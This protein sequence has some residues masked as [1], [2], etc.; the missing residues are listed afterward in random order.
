MPLDVTTLKNSIQ[1]AFTT[2][3]DALGATTLRDS[4]KTALDVAAATTDPNQ[5]SATRTTLAQS[6][7]D[8][9]KTF[10]KN[11]SP[12][13]A[14][15]QAVADAI[16]VFVSPLEG[17]GATYY[18]GSPANVGTAAPGI[19]TQV[20][21]GDHV[22]G[23]G[24]LAGGAFHAAASG[25]SAGF[26]STTDKDKLDSVTVANIP[27]VD[28]KAALAGTSGAPGDGNRYVT[29]ADSRNT[30]SRTP[31]AH[32]ASHVTGG[33][34]VIA[35]AVAGGAAGLLSGSDKSKLDGIEALADVTDLANVSAALGVTN[36]VA[37]ASTA[38]A[39]DAGKAVKLD[40]AGKLAPSF[41]FGDGDWY[42]SSGEDTIVN[43]APGLTNIAAANWSTATYS[44]VY[45]RY[46]ATRGSDGSYTAEHRI[47]INTATGSVGQGVFGN[48]QVGAPGFTFDAWRDG[49][50]GLVHFRWDTDNKASGNGGRIAWTAWARL[51]P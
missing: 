34:D 33:S 24:N 46:T 11:A 20:S 16:N 4:M 23:H 32:A 1:T 31:T 13:S 51:N 35:N 40:S 12:L 22:H 45:I 8:A 10:V 43:N 49:A 26:M 6:W 39:A 7:S 41:L 3:W 18:D 48:I 21:R 44:A 19:S 42:T 47:A 36:A 27:T 9:L 15:A 17:G 50:T 5:T 38:G 28:E 37:V 29:N 25:A 2:F 30:D 14:L